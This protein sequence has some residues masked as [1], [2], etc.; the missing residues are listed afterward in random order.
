[1]SDD[2]VHARVAAV[3]DLGQAIAGYGHG[4]EMTLQGARSDLNAAAARFQLAVARSQQRWGAAQRDVARARAALAAC[5]EGC[6]ALVAAVARCEATEQAARRSHERNCT[7][8]DHFE[9][10]AADLLSS[11]RTAETATTARVMP[12]RRQVQEYAEKLNAYL[13]TGV[14]G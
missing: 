1:M 9:R 11:M 14:S 4:V 10:T 13:Q 6:G 8:Q 12:A 7:A 3:R 2:V 5:R